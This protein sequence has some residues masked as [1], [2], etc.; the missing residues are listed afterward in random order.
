MPAELLRL[1]VP[2]RRA[3]PSRTVII[4]ALRLATTATQPGS[5]IVFLMGGPGIPGT[6]MAPIPP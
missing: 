5:P 3:H 4:G 6:V 2:V 1:T